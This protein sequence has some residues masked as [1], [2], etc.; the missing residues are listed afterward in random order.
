MRKKMALL[1]VTVLCLFAL[2]VLAGCGGQGTQQGEGEMSGNITAVGSTAVQP[3]MEQAANDFMSINPNVRIVVQGGGSGT[4]L[5]QVAQGAADIGN[6][7]IFAEEKSGID[8]AQL[9]DHQICVVGMA[10]VA[11]P[12]L[13]VDN[14]TRQ[15]V[16]DIFTGKTTNWQSVGGPDQKIVLVNRP[17][18][19]GTRATF[20]KY[21]L[22]GAEEAAGIEEDS[23]GTV[24]KI[25]KDT[26]GA[27]GY[28]ALAYLDDSVKVINLDGVE[29]TN[30]MIISGKYP[31]WA[32]MHS[33]TKGQPSGAT[34]AFLQYMSSDNVQKS[35]IPE[36]GYIPETEMKI[37]RDI[38]G[39]IKSK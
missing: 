36:M 32:Y 6:S 5:T 9:T 14:L 16:I 24:R 1:T 19:S 38:N 18:A 25:V 27:I 8:A 7:D 33:Y 17:K 39:N 11:N 4:G 22:G 30:E 26:P 37:V 35:I 2:A 34:E 31:L 10:C 3:L 28:L 20:K 23:S 15:Q 29:P 13:S 12:A 21:V